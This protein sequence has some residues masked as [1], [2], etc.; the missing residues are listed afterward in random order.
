MPSH[1]LFLGSRD[2][3]LSVMAAAFA[4]QVAGRECTT[5]FAALESDSPNPMAMAVLSEIIK[6]TSS[7][8]TVSIAK[9]QAPV[10]LVVAMDAA[11]AEACPNIPGSPCLLN[12]NLWEPDATNGSETALKE[13]FRSVRDTIRRLVGDFFDRG[14]LDTMAEC[15]AKFEIV[16]DNISDGIIG[17]NLDRTITH[18]NRSPNA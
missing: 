13:N 14:Y 2:T 17:H 15:S 6:D 1:I 16:F 11:A 9:L 12:W 3:S 7:L 5:S 4:R 18:F 10:N 8:K